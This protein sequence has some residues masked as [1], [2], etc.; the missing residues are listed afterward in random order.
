MQSSSYEAEIT[1]GPRVQNFIENK[2]PYGGSESL[3]Y[4]DVSKGKGTLY[5]SIPLRDISRLST[6]ESAELRMF[7]LGYEKE[8][9]P[10]KLIRHYHIPLSKPLFIELLEKAAVP[11]IFIDILADNNG[12]YTA[13]PI[14]PI[15]SRCPESFHLFITLPNTPITCFTLYYRYDVVKARTTILVVGR[16]AQR[17]QNRIQEIYRSASAEQSQRDS[18]IVVA[19]IIAEMSAIFEEE[20]RTRDREV[21]VEESRTGFAPMRSSAAANPSSIIGST[22]SLHTVA[23]HLQFLHR[24]VDF[25]IC[26]MEFLVQHHENLTKMCQKAN[27]IS[28][29]SAA[30]EASAEKTRRSLDLT[31]SCTR[32]R[33]R[34]IKEL[35]YRITAQIKIVDNMIMQNDSRA[36][37]AIAEQSQ[38]TAVDTKRESVAMRTISALTM[39]FLPGTFVGTIFGMAFF[40]FNEDGTRTMRVSPVWWLYVVITVPLTALVL[41]LWVGWLRWSMRSMKPQL[42]VSDLIQQSGLQSSANHDV[43]MEGLNGR[44]D[45][46]CSS[47]DDQHLY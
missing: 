8:K 46:D 6:H 35:I 42:R 19:A 2:I 10:Y 11:P 23:G 33:L 26:L 21:Q 7:F 14:T 1:Y 18:F 9:L 5:K 37:I 34:Q 41:G 30:I 29:V 36:T 47:V 32:T 38:R 20:R 3:D 22:R 17:Y 27:E 16:H 24:A 4:F 15:V 44:A 25:Q 43:E 45:D 31:I 28:D 12:V 39:V 13:Y 40:N